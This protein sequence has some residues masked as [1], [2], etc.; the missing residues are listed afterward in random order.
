M[1]RDRS[2]AATRFSRDDASSVT[3]CSR[4]GCGPLACFSTPRRSERNTYLR[5]QQHVG[6]AAN[7]RHLHHVTDSSHLRLGLPEGL[8]RRRSRGAGHLRRPIREVHP[9]GVQGGQQFP[10][11]SHAP[12]RAGAGAAGERGRARAELPA[13]RRAVPRWHGQPQGRSGRAAVLYST[14]QS[15]IATRLNR[16]GNLVSLYEVLGRGC[17]NSPIV[18][19]ETRSADRKR[20]RL[21]TALRRPRP[22]PRGQ[23]S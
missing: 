21:F 5:H 13:H 11:H 20:D 22:M 23:V 2:D 17:A 4:S 8:A 18:Q 15:L 7:Q 3:E 1:G 14:L 10:E 12:P 9:D 6:F 19:A 16:R